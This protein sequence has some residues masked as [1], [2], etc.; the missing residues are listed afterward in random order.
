MMSVSVRGRI[1]VGFATVLSIMVFAGVLNWVMINEMERHIGDYRKAVAE[2]SQG[3]QMDLQIATIRVRVNQWLRSM[4]PDFAKQAD[5]LLAQIVPMAQKVA[6]DSGP[7]QTQDNIK[8]L[9][10][11]T[12]AYTTSWGVIKGLYAEEAQLY[13]QDFVAVG[14]RVRAD[15]A[16]ARQA[17]ASLNAFRN[18][19]LLAD[20]TQSLTEAEKFALLNRASPK[21]DLAAH[22]AAAIAALL[23][24]VH[25]CAAA[26]QNPKTA[27]ALTAAA[28]DVSEWEK[29]FSQATTIAQTRA[30]R[31]VTWTRDEGEP[32]GKLADSIKVEGETQAELV[33][34]EQFAAIARGRS[35][36]YVITAAGVLIGAVLSWL[37]ARSIIKPLA[38]I[39]MA[40]KT[41]ASGDRTSEIPETH[42]G[43]EI[44]EMARSAEIFRATAIE[45]ERIAKEQETLKATAAAAQRT[46]MNQTADAF[47]AK[48]G[49][50]VS[51][52]S[53]G[54]TELQTTATS[55][56]AIATQTDQQAT[57]V[58]AAA[59]EASAG[60]QMVAAAAEELTASIHEI[61]RQ[62]DQSSKI[63][64][65]A[66]DDA[67]RTDGIVRALANAAQKIGDVVQLITGIAAQTNLL[68]LNA[69]IEAARAGDVGK[70][71]AVVASEVKDL[72]SQTAKATEE[73]G[74]QITQI[75]TTTNEAVQAIQAIGLTINEVN[76]IA[77]NIAAAVEEQGAATA[78]IAR[79]VQQTATNTQA[80]TVT[81]AGVRQAANDTGAAAGDLLGAASGLS[82]QAG[83]L[84]DEV[85]SFVAGIRAA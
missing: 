59:E 15:L 82:R 68:A 47:E 13:G 40:L 27:V 26:S 57:T 76:E 66:V 25:K 35:I 16:Q 73:I 72:A 8:K 64:A 60:V 3:Y 77:S 41:L 20:A 52:L 70:G 17:E 5:S 30:A 80:V 6:A 14:A 28:A 9:I 79:N 46:A 22:V 2:R 83:E 36:L 84:T 54:A 29:L 45:F 43:D 74:S 67:R 31:L 7:G 56:S 4:L 33:E 18:V 63:T 42:R 65:R 44:G 19:V 10:G 81:I 32:M 23:D 75:Q 55:M 21:A 48:F 58:A 62:V 38:Y 71:F 24:S 11:S 69:T 50:M 34:A 39:T 49:S 1:L 85:N 53:S 51:M 78:E 37:L 61:S 12:A